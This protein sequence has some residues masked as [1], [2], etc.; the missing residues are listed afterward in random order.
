MYNFYR[1][2]LSVRYAPQH[3]IMV[4][5][6]INKLARAQQEIKAGHFVKAQKLCEQVLREQS[7]HI[8]ALGLL[9]EITMQQGNFSF[10]VRIFQ[11]L[12]MLQPVQILHRFNLGLALMNT[13]S[14]VK[15]LS[16]FRE[17]TRLKPDFGQ[18]WSRQ[19]GTAGQLGLLEE[20]IDAGKKAV[21]FLPDSMGAH[22]NLGTAYDAFGQTSHALTHFRE[23]ARLAPNH[24]VVQCNLGN[25][26]VGT[27]DKKAADACYR[28]AIQ[29]QPS[30]A[31][32]YRQLSR[33]H[34]YA[35]CEHEDFG[36]ITQQLSN[37]S[38]PETTGCHLH[39]ALGKM[40]EDCGQYGDA[41]E[42]IKAG[43]QIINQSVNFDANAYADEITELISIYTKQR[44]SELSQFG[45]STSVPIF[46]V[47]MPRSGTTLVE[48]II[49]SHSECLGAGELY[50]FG[51]IEPRIQQ[52]LKSD[53]PY[54]ECVSDLDER[55]IKQLSDEFLR[56]LSILSEGGSQ[57]HIVDKFPDNYK[58][59]GIIA[60]M[61]PNARIIYCHRN[62]LDVCFSLYSIYFPGGLGYTYDLNNVAKVY[63]QHE[64][65]MKHWQAV[66]PGRILTVSY[67]NLVR[68]QEMV[69]RE[70]IQYIDI[71]WD[72]AC[73]TFSGNNSRVL[74]MSAVQVRQG[75]YTSAVGRWRPF[76]KYLSPLLEIFDAQK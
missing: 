37:P 48:Q 58:N 33:L 41:F 59:L 27:G 24:P 31:E 13:G 73:L 17:V 29:L 28:K 55:S 26:L 36:A 16:H 40:Y 57:K 64:R 15:A 1:Y 45:N 72:D 4:P 23:A 75:M 7:T 54:P 71:P 46:I 2:F 3:F 25:A 12:L 68:E 35:S 14:L 9:G 8:G 43:N 5:Q 69:T 62:P 63:Q 20:S 38:M 53:R 30:Y 65:L 10:A 39:F 18:A 44:V 76:E 47:G 19:C 34:T 32:P 66:L 50:W 22:L 52:L 51:Q 42:H 11:Q 67:E 61:F 21:D 70:I 49:A 56:Y 74:T 60:A 6:L